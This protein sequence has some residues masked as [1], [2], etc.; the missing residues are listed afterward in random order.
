MLTFAIGFIQ[1]VQLGCFAIVFI[2]MALLDRSNR[3]FRWLAAI[4]HRGSI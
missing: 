2:L 3:G 1:N 4:S